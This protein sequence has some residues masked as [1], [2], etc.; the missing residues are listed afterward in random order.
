MFFYRV[1]LFC[2]I[3][4]RRPFYYNFFWQ[5]IPNANKQGVIGLKKRVI[6]SL[7]IVCMLC[8]L[9]PVQ[10]LASDADALEPAPAPAAES[11]A[12]PAPV[13]AAEPVADPAPA[14]AAESAPAPV[15]EPAAEPAAEPSMESAV[16]PAAEPAAESVQESAVAP[17]AEPAAEP[18]APAAAVSEPVKVFFRIFPEDA[19]FALTVYTKDEFGQ[20]TEIKSEPDGSYKLVPGRYFYAVEAEGYASLPEKDFEV[21]ASEQPLELFLT[22]NALEPKAVEEPVAAVE[23]EAVDEPETV[24][25][26]EA[27]EEPE[28]ATEEPEAVE[29]AKAAEDSESEKKAEDESVSNIAANVTIEN[30]TPLTLNEE[31]AADITA[32]G[33]IAFFSFTPSES[34]VYIFKALA[35]D[36]TYGYLYDSAKNQIASDD[37][38]GD[39]NNF[40]I[41]YELTAGSTYYYGARWYDRTSQTGS[42]PVILTY[43]RF[44]AEAKG[45]TYLDVPIG[46]TKTLEVVVKG[47]GLDGLTYQWYKDDEPIEG[48]TASSF[49]AASESASYRCDVSLDGETQSVYYTVYPDLGF[50][51]WATGYDPDMDPVHVDVPFGETVTLSVSAEAYDGVEIEYQ[52]CDDETWSI[53]EGA[54]SS[55][56]TTEAITEIRNYR[57]IVT[58]KYGDWSSQDDVSFELRIDNGFS[59]YVT[60]TNGE[61]FSNV[62]VDPGQTATLSV[63]ATA[64]DGELAYQWKRSIT[65]EWGDWSYSPIDGATGPSITTEAIVS[66]DENDYLCIVTDKY[67]NSQN[68]EFSIQLR[69]TLQAFVAGTQN[70]SINYRVAYGEA[71]T[72]TVD[73]T[74]DSGEL[75]YQWYM[76][77]DPNDSWNPVAVSDVTGNEYTIESVTKYH[78]VYCEVSDDYG[79]SV[80]CTSLSLSTPA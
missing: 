11:A 53:I 39:D 9:L 61:T 19:A 21:K 66:D 79:H 58:G 73:A 57:C 4:N 80:D 26:S 50:H 74:V 36:D 69:N 72:L 29:E 34:G 7:L 13:P 71:K 52:W 18:E 15:N 49:T 75:H 59:A 55:E 43:L 62:Y 70:N 46:S 42:F 33:Q 17:A 67:G 63:T 51:A 6:S 28:A 78:A 16:E 24:E 3:A 47:S 54:N 2:A 45:D 65:D 38:S 25:K 5:I 40:L 60:G 77:A 64:R 23:A 27:A 12:E 32:P 22:L 30:P 31:A 76:I 37:D 41:R 8:T 56:F 14:P 20:K 48:A 1:I 10:A 35:D 68:I 44:S